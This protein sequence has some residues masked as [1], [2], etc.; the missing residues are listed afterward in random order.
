GVQYFIVQSIM[1]FVFPVMVPFG[2]FLRALPF[3]RE[4]GNTVLAISFALIV[5]F[6][7]SYAVNAFAADSASGLGGEGSTSLG[8]VAN[9]L[10]QTIFLPNLALV[11]TITGATAMVKAAKVIP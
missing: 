6:P 1:G 8:N 9:Y 4:A 2:L 7:F 11:V 3:L 10:L 5:I